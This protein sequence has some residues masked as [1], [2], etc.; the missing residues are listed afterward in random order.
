MFAHLHKVKQT[1]AGRH[2]LDVRGQ[3]LMVAVE[4]ASPTSSPLDPAHAP[5]APKNLASRVAKR[6]IEKGMYI[7]TTSV[8]EVIR[9]IP[10]L[11]ISQEDMTKGTHY[12]RWHLGVTKHANR[13]RVE[14]DYWTGQRIRPKDVTAQF[15]TAVQAT[16]AVRCSLP[17]SLI[18]LTRQRK[19]TKRTVMM[20]A[21]R[22]GLYFEI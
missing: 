4:F 16:R 9:F 7:L 12:A 13:K 10:P 1:E 8:Y 11:N 22:T 18:M 20:K 19:W 15:Q 14:D 6:C 21:Q 2:I 17:F 5:R 3:G